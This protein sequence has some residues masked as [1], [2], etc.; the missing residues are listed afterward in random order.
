MS[1]FV[2]YNYFRSSTSYRARIALHLKGIEFEYKPV[3]LIAGEQHHAAFKQL[4]PDGGVPALIHKGFA[5]SQSMA[6]LEYLDDVVPTPRL[7]PQDVQK[8]ALVR[9]FCE[10][11]NC[12][13]PYQ[14]L[15]TLKFLENEF[16]LGA[17]Q[18][19]RWVQNFLKKN[20]RAQETLLERYSGTFSFGGEV[21][22][23]DAFLLPQ[24]FSSRRM[25]VAL[26][27][28]P[29]VLRVEKN[30]LALSAFQKAH[31]H[32]QVDTPEELKGNI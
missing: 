2:L 16:G 5:V 19:D 13:H 30:C 32:F 21:T 27:D 29:N 31:P 12:I 28:F 26:T 1:D 23:A 11:I 8:G 7:F 24:I 9:Q 20:M 4:N 14:N 10:N 25:G 15:Q 18:R 17:P 3:S 6:I 22:A